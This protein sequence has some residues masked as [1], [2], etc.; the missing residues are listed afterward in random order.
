M[1]WW[2][3]IVG[4]RRLR[5]PSF[6]DSRPRVAPPSRAVAIADHWPTPPHVRLIFV[7][8]VTGIAVSP[9]RSAAVGSAR[10]GRR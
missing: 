3:E 7:K 9:R 10:G 4:S 8:P 5:R 2:S 6:L 1:R